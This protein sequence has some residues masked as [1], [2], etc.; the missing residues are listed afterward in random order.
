MMITFDESELKV[1]ERKVLRKINGDFLID[2]D[3]YRSRWNYELY[4]IYG[5]I[6]IVQ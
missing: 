5:D 2:N 1:F 3:E 4:E 6:N